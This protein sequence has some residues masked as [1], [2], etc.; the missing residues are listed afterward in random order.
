VNGFVLGE[1]HAREGKG[2]GG[3][4]GK[5]GKKKGRTAKRGWGGRK[6][7][8]GLKIT[9]YPDSNKSKANDNN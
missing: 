7:A 4:K 9:L 8:P 6:L 5:P 3:T 1:N 2:E